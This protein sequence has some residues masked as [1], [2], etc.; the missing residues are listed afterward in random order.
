MV[1]PAGKNTWRFQF[2]FKLVKSGQANQCTSDLGKLESWCKEHPYR[3]LDSKLRPITAT[4][5]NE[6][7]S[8]AR[9]PIRQQFVNV[10]RPALATA[11]PTLPATALNTTPS[12]T[13]AAGFVS[14]APSNHRC[15]MQQS[16]SFSKVA[17]GK[18]TRFSSMAADHRG[19][20]HQPLTSKLTPTS[21]A[22]E[23]HLVS[24]RTPRSSMAP[25]MPIT[26]TALAKLADPC[27]L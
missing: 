27:P 25:N 16:F 2:Y 26:V 4:F 20:K 12:L 17:K 11:T 6:S 9:V 24:K 8:S 23:A 10:V 15:P 21:S 14:A 13:A 22:M 7:S 5:L 19:T 3:G 1:P 18:I